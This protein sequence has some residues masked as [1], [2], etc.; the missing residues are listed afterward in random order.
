MQLGEG[1]PKRFSINYVSERLEAESLVAIQTLQRT[2][3][4]V[5][6]LHSSVVINVFEFLYHFITPN[7]KQNESSKSYNLTIEYIEPPIPK[8]VWVCTSTVLVYVLLNT[9]LRA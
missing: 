1:P 2:C 9:R 6:L 8:S 4:V 7:T 3:K 5:Q